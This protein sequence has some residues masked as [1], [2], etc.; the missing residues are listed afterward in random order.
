MHYQTV[1]IVDRHR[2]SFSMD[3]VATILHRHD[4]GLNTRFGVN[5][6]P[7]RYSQVYGVGQSLM[8][9]PLFVGLRVVK[10]A[11]HLTI[12]TDL[13]LWCLNWPVFA[14]L[15]VMLVL[16]MCWIAG[17]PGVAWPTLITFAAAFSSPIWMFSNLP[18]NVVG[19][20]L[21]MAARFTSACCSP[22]VASA[23]DAGDSIAAA[24]LAALLMSSSQSVVFATRCRPS[25][26]GSSIRSGS[27]LFFREEQRAL[28]IAVTLLAGGA[29]PP[30]SRLF[31]WPAVDIGVSRPRR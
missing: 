10:N 6:D 31:L 27:R 28:T 13:T 3:D 16:G 19:E 25:R 12:P 8:T 29:A 4:I 21:V 1:Q 22:S 2:L 15:C 26:D 23:N 30:R 18:F 9:L 24:E 17:V 5:R 11:L 14:V 7:S 20:T